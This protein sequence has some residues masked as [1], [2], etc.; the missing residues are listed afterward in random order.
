MSQ[1]H[2]SADEESI[3][4]TLTDFERISQPHLGDSFSTHLRNSQIHPSFSTSSSSWWR[5]FH[6]L[7]TT[8]SI[9]TSTS[10]RQI[11]QALLHPHR[12][13]SILSGQRLLQHTFEEN[14]DAYSTRPNTLLDGFMQTEMMIKGDLS[15]D[16]WSTLDG[17]CLSFILPFI[18]F[19]C[20]VLFLILR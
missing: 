15:D 13:R 18:L 8:A 10:P 7:A 17:I 4:P 16:I 6:F 5:P 19:Y 12:F 3:S 2:I 9:I 1:Q 20:F 11:L 14:V